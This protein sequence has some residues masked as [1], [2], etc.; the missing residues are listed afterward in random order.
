[1]YT[2]EKVNA[3]LDALKQEV[4]SLL[5]F[6]KNVQRIEVHQWAPG[7]PESSLMYSC[8]LQETSSSILAARRYITS[9][10]TGGLLGSTALPRAHTLAVALHDGSGNQNT[11]H[12]YLISQTCGGGISDELAKAASKCA[13][14]LCLMTCSI[15]QPC[16]CI[17]TAI[18]TLLPTTLLY[19]LSCLERLRLILI[20][21]SMCCA[22]CS[23]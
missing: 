18:Q 23:R 10:A 21:R 11:L 16:R 19:Y 20:G 15:Q 14:R 9:L 6:L 13:M 2:W 5:L 1:M 12:R 4:V 17:C 22:V 3:L 8:S 7:R